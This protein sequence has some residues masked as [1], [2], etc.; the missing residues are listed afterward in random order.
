MH[1]QSQDQAKNHQTWET[2]KVLS[3]GDWLQSLW[4][5]LEMRGDVTQ[6]LLTPTQAVFQ[7]ETL[8]RASERGERLLKSFDT[9]KTAYRAWELV[10]QWCLE[11]DFRAACENVDHETFVMWADQYAAWLEQNQFIDQPSLPSHILQSVQALLPSH[12]QITLYAFDSITPQFRQFFKTL[13]RQGIQ[14]ET[15]NPPLI[16]PGSC[17][18]RAFSD[19]FVEA[20][21]CALWAKTQMEQGQKNIA[22][23]VPNLPE[24]RSALERVLQETIDVALGMMP[25]D[26]YCDWLNFSAAKPLIQYPLIQDAL[27]FLQLSLPPVAKSVAMRALLSP[28][29]TGYF[30]AVSERAAQ[31]AAL[32]SSAKQTLNDLF[33]LEIL[34]SKSQSYCSLAEWAGYFRDILD[35]LGWPGDRGLNSIEHQVVKRFED[36]LA[37]FGQ[38]GTV[39]SAVGLAEA[40]RCLH[41]LISNT[42]FQPE[43]KS[44]RVQVLGT[45]EAS[46]LYFDT[47]WILGLHRDAW[48][49]FSHTNPFIAQTLQRQHQFPHASPEHEMIYA[50]QVTE[51]LKHCATDII[52]SYP[53]KEADRALAPSPLIADLP[54]QLGQA[55]RQRIE[56]IFTSQANTLEY[57]QD[58][59]A[60]ALEGPLRGGSQLLQWQAEC[61]FKAFAQT[62]LDAVVTDWERAW[63]EPFEKG[64]ILHALLEALW[65][66]LHDQAQLNALTAFDRDNLL[67]GLIDKI[68]PKFLRKGLSDIYITIEK[69]RLRQL[70]QDYCA[71]EKSRPYFSVVA[72]EWSGEYVLD[73]TTIRLRLDRIDRDQDGHLWV[74]DYKTGDF[75]LNR[76]YD[77]RLEAVQL[78]LYYLAMSQSWEQPY[79]VMVMQLDLKS[80]KI[81]SVSE[82]C[83]SLQSQ[84]EAGIEALVHEYREGIARVSP[85]RGDETCRYCDLATFCRRGLHHDVK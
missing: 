13:D 71:L 40:L 24:R 22:I 33:P 14:T 7:W 81:Q 58:N 42:P 30:E 28:F 45:L 59:T 32:K 53:L 69:T 44:P 16:T 73:K 77:E 39:L 29:S 37:E 43:S 15:V 60:P 5:A 65:R 84:W 47:A 1:A 75:K 4:D 8:I 48:P 46:G 52:F 36:L 51:R 19:S 38:V 54:M 27:L 21:A 78:P 11:K 56:Q 20:Q 50:Q 23:I 79:G 63:L 82:E 9:A 83:A 68:L 31:I 3:L 72:T 55:S 49:E 2:P 62:R 25:V 12:T 10:H 61:P 76:I 64:I 41:Q 26:P 35:T 67:Q 18:R 74:V 57:W 17:E 85:N 34:Q 6:L 66:S 70:L 80:S